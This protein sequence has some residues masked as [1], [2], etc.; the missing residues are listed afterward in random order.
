MSDNAAVEQETSGGRRGRGASGGAAARRAARSGGGPGTQ[1]TYIKRKINVYEVLNEE[2][3]ALIEKNTDTVLE[4]TGIIF[5]DDAEALALWKEAGADVKGE[6]V[7]FPKGLCRSLLK[8][9]P[10]IYTQHARNPE[11][12]VQIGGNATVFAPVY[13]PPFVRD[14]DGNR[15]YATIE[16]FQNFVKLAYMAPSIHHSGGTVCEPVDVPVN[17][18]HLDMIYAHIRYS[19]KPFMGSVTAPERA[20]D[21]V[22]MAKLVF[23][24]D[25]VENNTVLTSLINANSPM[26]FDETMLGA[27]KVYSRHNQACIVT[28]FILAGAMSPV[29]VAGTLTQVLAEVLAG[30]SFTQLIKPGA[31]VLFGTFASSIS[32]QSGAPTF[33]TPEPSLV[34]YGAAQLARRLG[35]PFRTGGSLCASKIPDAQAAYESANTLNS[36][37]LAGT[38][39]VLHSAGWLEGGLASCYEK[40]MMDI[41]QLGMQ[42]KFCEGVDLSENG[43]AMDAIRQVGPGS[44]YLGCDHTQANFQTAFYRSNIADNNSYEQW[45]AEGEKTA[46]QRANELARR[47]LESYEAPHLDPAIDE[48]LKDFIAKKKGS[49]PDAFT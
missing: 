46:P 1:L 43:Q 44:H 49:M 7:H 29:T 12:S 27:L 5:R 11:R 10:S 20:E 40:F 38:N 48:A 31:P 24:D 19:D 4:E 33:G 3:L 32:M 42:Q 25:F 16:D 14:L 18:R 9:A 2:G 45:L 23:G 28:P 30:A 8:T 37:I 41:D 34:S 39:F 15:R 17:K 36:T 47:W 21:T 22:A 26:V 13:G 6:R 35:L